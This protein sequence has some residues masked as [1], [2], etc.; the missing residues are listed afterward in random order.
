VAKNGEKTRKTMS[1]RDKSHYVKPMT[2][3]ETKVAITDFTFGDLKTEEVI[4]TPLGCKLV[5][6]PCR[7]EAEL[8]DLVHSA[9]FVITQFAPL[10][11]KVIDS[12]TMARLIVRYGIGVDNVNID[13]ATRKRIPVC[14][15]PDYCVDE[16][17]DHTLALILA[18]TRQVAHISAQ[19]RLGNWRTVVPLEKMV[20]LKNK[21]VGLVGFGRIGR[22]VMQRLRPFKCRFVIHDPGIKRDEI[23]A[24]G[25]KAASLNELLQVS[26]IVSLHCPSIPSTRQLINRDTLRRMRKS[27]LLIN[28]ARGSVVHQNDLI[29]ALQNGTIAGAGLDVSDPEPINDDSPLLKMESVIITNHVASCS[30]EA[31]KMLRQCVAETV[32]MGVRGEPLPNIVNPGVFEKKRQFVAP[33]T[34]P[35]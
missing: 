16:V 5:A 35:R 13:A 25:A 17:A 26:D 10:S 20:V 31:I 6:S 30:V 22:E 15:V 7:N 19:V 8:I 23:A 1:K 18:L 3:H 21:T 11:S 28:V 34:E 14:N 12:M 9:D 32:A 27:A 33:M 2:V 24:A 29:T 4:L